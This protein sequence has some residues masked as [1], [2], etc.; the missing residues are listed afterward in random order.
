MAWAGWQAL[1][2]EGGN[3]QFGMDKATAAPA[4]AEDG[5][6]PPL[7]HRRPTPPDWQTPRSSAAEPPP[8]A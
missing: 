6:Y 4:A 7:R 1:Q 5:R 8:D 3:W 2:R